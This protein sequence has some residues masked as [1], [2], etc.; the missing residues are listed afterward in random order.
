MTLKNTI[1]IAVA[2][3]LVSCSGDIIKKSSGRDPITVRVDTI[4]ASTANSGHSFIGTVSPS[5]SVM[6]R[7]KFSG[8][9]T[10]VNIRQGDRVKQGDVIAEVESQNVRSTYDMAQATLRQAEDGY[11]RLMKLKGT[12]SVPE[13]KVIE[14]E[15]QLQQAR[16]SA[17][18]AAQALKECKI[19]A[20]FD[21]VVGDVMVSAGI[22]ISPTEVIANIFDINSLEVKISVSENEI[23]NIATGDPATL[24]IPALN[25]KHLKA[26]ISTKGV[27]ASTLSHTYDC[28]LNIIGDADELMPGMVC[29]VYMQT[30]TENRITIPANVVKMDNIGKYVWSVNGNVVE[31]RYI[32]ISGF[33]GRRIVVADGL[34]EGDI[35]ITDGSQKISTGM[36][37]S[38]I[39]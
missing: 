34:D 23:G 28:I 32:T 36:T 14:V 17:E 18:A 21:G 16:S 3:I 25:N 7:N 24:I 9:L 13:I 12:N 38:V 11:A 22:D 26:H 1:L 4:K 20:P 19:T 29:K 8:R 6:M 31:K 15:T 10:T 5:K 33:S 27:I 39:D 2:T 30:K 37:V 35:V